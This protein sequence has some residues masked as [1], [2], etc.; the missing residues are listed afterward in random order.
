MVDWLE[1]LATVLAVGSD[2]LSPVSCVCDLIFTLTQTW[3]CGWRSLGHVQSAL[4][5]DRYIACGAQ[6]QMTCYSR[7]SRCRCSHWLRDSCRLSE[8]ARGQVE[9]RCMV[10]FHRSLSGPYSAS[11]VQPSLAWISFRLAVMAYRCLQGS[12]VCTWR[13]IC[14]ES[15][16]STH[17]GDCMRP[18]SHVHV[19][20]C[21]SLHASCYHWRL[22]LAGDCHICMEKYAGVST[23][24][25]FCLNARI[26][27]SPQH[28]S[29]NVQHIKVCLK[30]AATLLL[31]F[32]ATITALAFYTV[33]P[34]KGFY[35]VQYEHIKR[36][37]VGCAHC[38]C[39]KFPGVCFYQE[40]A[41]LDDIWVWSD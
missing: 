19:G 22:G 9:Y 25:I 10:D 32:N 21:L 16:T 29:I 26:T 18:S 6:C 17:V 1:Q 27:P 36:G 8:T 5:I 28:L 12:A 34:K 2:L 31:V 37:V 30:D 14:G 15:Q 4:M 24:I 41:K 38:V 23:G 13:E 3:R 39:F 20:Q 35:K 7:L 33:S 40:L 11:I